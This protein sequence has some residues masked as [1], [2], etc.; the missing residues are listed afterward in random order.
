MFYPDN[1]DC[2]KLL[3]E[4]MYSDEWLWLLMDSKRMIVII[5]I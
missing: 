1:D 3:L 4:Q 5:Q 2:D